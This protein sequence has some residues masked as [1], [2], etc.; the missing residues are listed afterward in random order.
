MRR[1]T[2]TATSI[3]LC[4]EMLQVLYT[5]SPLKPR[6]KQVGSFYS[7]FSLFTTNHHFST[8][9]TSS[10]SSTTQNNNTHID[11]SSNCFSGIAQTVMLKCSQFSDKN[12]GKDFANASLKDLLL[13]ISD[14]VPEQTRRLRRVSQ[15]KPEDALELLLGFELQCGKVGFKARKVES[16]WEIFKWVSEKI[17]GF[18]HKPQS[19]EVMASILVRVGLLRE[20]ESLLST[21]ESQGILLDSQ[22]IFSDLIEG[23]VGAGELERAIS[24]YD[25]IRGRLVPTS[26]CCGALLKQ[27]VGMRKTQLASRVCMDMAEMGFDLRDVKKAT[28]EGVIRLLCRDGKIQEARNLIKKGMAFDFKP[29]NLV[30]NEVAYGYC[31]KKDFDDLLSFYADIKCAPD[32]MAGNRI[33]HS[34]CSNFGTRRAEPFLQELEHSGFNLDEITF[35]I[36]IGWSCREGK[37]KSAF[38]YLSEMLARHLKPHKCTYNALISGVFMEGMWKHAGEVFDEMVDRGTTP[39]FSTFRILLA[40]YCKARQ[41]DEAK[42]I[43]FYMAKHGLIQNSSD[44][45]PLSRAFRILG[46]DPLAVTLKRD[47]D[48]GFSKTEFYDDLGNGLYL[49]T[50]LDEYEERVTG[51]L[52]DCMVPDYNSLMMKECTLGNLKGALV[53]VDE[54]IRWGQDLSLSMI[55]ALLRGLSVF[56]SHTKAITSIVDSKL[57]LVH[58]L[59]QEALNLLAQAYIK[60]GLAYNARIVLNGMIER[61]LKIKNET[62]TYLVKGFCKKG[63]SRELHAYWN[64]AQNDRWLPGPEDCKALIECLCNKE[65]LREAVQ[66]LEIIL[67]SYPHLRSDICHMFVDKLFVSGFTRIASVLLDELEQRGSVLDQMAYT[68]LIRGLCKEKN[69]PVAFTVLDNML[70]KSWAP[71]LDVTVELI[72]QLCR[73]DRFGKAVYLKEIDLRENSSF[74]LSLDRALIEGCCMSGKVTEATTLLQN[75]L[76]NGTLP[77]AEIYNFLVQGHCKVNNLKTVR[78]LLGFMTRNSFSI[79]LSTYRN[80]VRLM[81]LER[82]VLHAW[83][84]K[85][86]MIEQSDPHDLSIYNIL[87]FYIFPTGNT[88]V[89]KKVVEHLQEKKFILDEVTYNFLVHGFC[90]FKDVSSAVDHLYAMISMDFRPSNRNLRKVITD[91]CDIG[92]IEKALELSREMQLRGWTHDSMIQNAI[93]DGLLSHGRAQEAENFLDR[94]VEKCLIP[95]NINYDNLIKLFCWYGRPNKAVNL[96][97]IMLKKGNIPESNSYDSMICSFSALGNLERAMEF[98]TEMLDRNLRPSIDSWD[99]LVHNFCGD[100]KTAEA[101][102]LLKCMVCAGETVTRKIYSSVINRYRLENNLGKVSELMQA[103]QQSGYEPDF[104]T[105]WS[106]IRNLRNS[107]DK[108]NANSSKGFLSKLLSA[109]GFSRQKYSKARQE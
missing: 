57:H 12:K 94:M 82:R 65:M 84:L 61:H 73:A 71:C 64:I 80:L 62:Y 99:I 68:Y 102:R 54:M 105:H 81:C 83:R 5:C 29:S 1:R 49:D 46:F 51:I 28:F 86:L 58:Q 40:G 98:H 97:D 7:L 14:L 72:P 52:E 108:D 37:L 39:D 32:V 50:D 6:I 30:L 69:F 101:E 10:S 34:L 25:R 55:S 27:L 56:H 45:D 95:E 59:D 35:G 93:V 24:V 22:E 60:K 36:M 107:S 16:L 109:S 63:N 2:T 18:K 91:L 13:E 33:M 77:D 17:K 11:L 31:E 43:I 9:T 78:E 19:C 88:F 66:L 15:L 38:V 42:R 90:R 47:N 76:L 96:L 8:T 92:E 106:L 41:F 79:S 100:G 85:E 67:I 104:E 70:A 23:Y 87:I 48:V 74:S 75:M 3:A 4:N 53:L 44:E 89:V 103:M 26:Q 21:M 20:V